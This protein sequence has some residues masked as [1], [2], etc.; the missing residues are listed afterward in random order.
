MWKTGMIFMFLLVL[1]IWDLRER[2]VPLILLV[3]GS[4]WLGGV[5]GYELFTGRISWLYL[6]LGSLAGVFFLLLAW[7]SGKAGYAD[8]IVLLWLGAAEGYR[9]VL[10][11]LVSSLLLVCLSAI[12]LLMFGKVKKHT[13]IPYIPFLA[14]GYVMTKAAF[15]GK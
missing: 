4:I 3:A 11:I 15:G 10:L 5:L 6:L 9:K 12:T 7:I 14:V 13:R 8:G 2:R 1:S